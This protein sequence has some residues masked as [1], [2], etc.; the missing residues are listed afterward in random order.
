[1]TAA[2]CDAAHML[3][4][5]LHIPTH[6]CLAQ[7]IQICSVNHCLLTVQF[8][9]NTVDMQPKHMCSG[10]KISGMLLEHQMQPSPTRKWRRAA[11][12]GVVIP[13]YGRQ[14][15]ANVRLDQ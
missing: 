11:H 4:T 2:Q 15:C 1:M 10:V 12:P 13:C 3:S 5:C 14:D 9:L 7:D 6:D 8:Q